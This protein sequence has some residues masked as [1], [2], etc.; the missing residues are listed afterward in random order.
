MGW[1]AS[2]S[3]ACAYDL[4]TLILLGP[5]GR[6]FVT[7]T[8]GMTVDEALAALAEGSFTLT[9]ITPTEMGNWTGQRFE[10]VLDLDE[11]TANT[12]AKYERRFARRLREIVDGRTTLL[13]SH[14]VNTVRAADRVVVMRDGEI[15]ETGTPDELAAADGPFVELLAKGRRA[16]R[17]Q[18]R[19]V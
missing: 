11:P 12:D 3:L 4:G 8:A 16:Q 10:G 7:P 13:I 1:S 9:N 14:Q 18:E 2:D 5:S 15:I 19:P 6:M 17:A